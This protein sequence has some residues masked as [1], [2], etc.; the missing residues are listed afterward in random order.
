M[1]F[2]CESFV[3]GHCVTRVIYF[4]YWTNFCHKTFVKVKRISPWYHG[5]VRKWN[6]V[7]M[8]HICK[9]IWCDRNKWAFLP[10]WRVKQ[11]IWTVLQQRGLWLVRIEL[12]LTDFTLYSFLCK[13]ISFCTVSF[14]CLY[15]VSAYSNVVLLLFLCWLGWRDLPWFVT[16]RWRWCLLLNYHFLLLSC[17]LIF[18]FNV[19]TESML[20]ELRNFTS[21]SL[22]NT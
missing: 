11:F 15:I 4:Q 5:G 2:L 7:F 20:V 8:V 21:L 10:Y 22:K 18:Q 14:P 19:R 17:I 6:S 1:S 3:L 16:S 9:L 12:S 13:S